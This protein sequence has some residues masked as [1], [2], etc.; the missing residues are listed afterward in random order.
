MSTNLFSSYCQL[1]RLEI[2]FKVMATGGWLGRI[3][4]G[5]KSVQQTA[6]NR[7][8]KLSQTL[9]DKIKEAREDLER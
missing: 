6:Q 5:A 1:F 8:E 4:S 2:L 3:K 9:D 7:L